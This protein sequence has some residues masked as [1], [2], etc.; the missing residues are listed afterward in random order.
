[1]TYVSTGAY[2]HYVRPIHPGGADYKAFL[3]AAALEVEAI[4]AVQPTLVFDYNDGACHHLFFL[5]QPLATPLPAQ[6]QARGDKT[7]SFHAAVP[8]TDADEHWKAL[9]REGKTAQACKVARA[10]HGLSLREAKDMVDNY[11]DRP[12]P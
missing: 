1:M 2:R 7:V 12:V 5:D 9:A 6:W 3:N 4:R 11:Q 10:V 8:A